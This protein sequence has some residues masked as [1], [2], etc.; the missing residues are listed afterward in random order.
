M[1]VVPS[2]ANFSSTIRYNIIYRATYHLAKT[3]IEIE[4]IQTAQ[5]NEEDMKEIKD[6]R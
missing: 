4:E 2:L 5:L 3:K 1:S 6:N